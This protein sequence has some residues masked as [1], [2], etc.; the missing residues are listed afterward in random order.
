MGIRRVKIIEITLDIICIIFSVYCIFC[1]IIMLKDFLIHFNLI[2]VSS[3]LKNEKFIEITFSFLL[4]SF[5][6]GILFYYSIRRERKKEERNQRLEWYNEVVLRS[7]LKNIQ[8]YFD[9]TEEFLKN[10]KQYGKIHREKRNKIRKELDCL[11]MFD[12]ILYSKIRDILL[13]SI[14]NFTSEESIQIKMQKNTLLK[15]TTLQFL[16]EKTK[17]I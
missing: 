17:T 15:I 13:E 12:K 3:K 4:S 1:I 8:D 14:D 7:L 16:F 5:F 10:T 6:S 2:N 9:T 11:T